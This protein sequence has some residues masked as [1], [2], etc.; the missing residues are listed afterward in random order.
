MVQRFDDGYRAY[1]YVTR[2]RDEAPDAAPPVGPLWTAATEGATPEQALSVGVAA[3]QQHGLVSP[4]MDAFSRAVESPRDEVVASATLNRA[5]IWTHI[6]RPWYGMPVLDDFI[7]RHSGNPALHEQVALAWYLRGLL[8]GITNSYDAAVEAFQEF[9][10]RYHRDP[11]P[12]VR[13]HVLLALINQAYAYDQLGRF[14][15]ACGVSERLIEEF[16][17]DPTHIEGVATARQNRGAMLV[18]L[19]R[20][21]EALDA[22]QQIID[23]DLPASAGH[24][25]ATAQVRKARVLKDLGNFEQALEVLRW[26]I[27]NYDHD[28]DKFDG[29]VVAWARSLCVRV[30]DEMGR[31]VDAAKALDDLVADYG[32]DPRASNLIEQAKGNV[33]PEPAPPKYEM[34]PLWFMH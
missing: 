31:S 7:S 19:H 17:D 13:N 1:D 6:G 30:L 8:N 20:L 33:V 3:W 12:S 21:P 29:V 9:I 25:V 11:E 22:F 14:E 16:G 2:L 15:D 18:K 34:A 26:V 24:F 32:D 28:P 10:D 5:V 27:E 4:A 23:S